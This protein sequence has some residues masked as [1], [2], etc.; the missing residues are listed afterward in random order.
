M[1]ISYPWWESTHA[2]FPKNE[3]FEK[4]IKVWISI[5]TKS[6]PEIKEYKYWSKNW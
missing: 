6:I 2:D 4:L 1:H 3:K 5:K